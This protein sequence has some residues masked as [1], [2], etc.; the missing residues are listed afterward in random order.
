M[1]HFVAGTNIGD[2]WLSAFAAIDAAGGSL[3]NLAVDISDP[4]SEDL[5]VRGAIERALVGNRSIQNAQSMHTVANTIFPISLYRPEAEDAADRFMT[6]A[7]RGERGRRHARSRRWGTYLGRLIA[8]PSPD[9][10]PTN[11]LSAVL[12]RLREPE[13]HYSDIYEVPVAVPGDEDAPCWEADGCTITAG[14]TLHGD[15][16]TDP[17]RRG[18]PCLAHLSV[19]LDKDGSVSMLALY[20]RHSYTPRAYGNFLGLARLLAFLA[21][22]SHHE[23]GSLM[24]VTGHAVPDATGRTALLRA[25]TAAAGDVQPIETG[26]RPLGASWADLDLPQSSK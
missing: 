3:V 6:N 16:R 25:A 24:V 26:A 7:A 20:R 22:E 18:G 2:A 21:H 4:C 11:Q 14:A 8:Y 5:G 19:T 9:G 17:F 15:V 13:R 12:S 10:E 1:G 23:V